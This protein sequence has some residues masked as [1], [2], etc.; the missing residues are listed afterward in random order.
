MR[1]VLRG[2][3][4]LAGRVHRVAATTVPGHGHVTVVSEPRDPLAAHHAV[5]R[6][7]N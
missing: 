6:E 7:E 3:P 5:R 4:S 2:L 1:V